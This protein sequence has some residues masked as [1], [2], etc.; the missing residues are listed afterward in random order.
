MA[1]RRKTATG[2]RQRPKRKDAAR[3]SVAIDTVPLP[4]KVFGMKL[5][6]GKISRARNKYILKVGRRKSELPIGPLLRASDVR[7]LAG[8][9]VHV[10]LS[11]TRKTE[12]VAIGTWPT[13]E[14]PTIRPDWVICYIPAPDM[15]HRVDVTV[16]RALIAK[17]VREKIITSRMAKEV[18]R[19]LKG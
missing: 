6:K 4:E 11:N 9:E 8:K 10:A 14:R 12:V 16:Q 18:M 5:A 7:R 1:T 15:M 3:G 19:G 13:P 2:K 17:M